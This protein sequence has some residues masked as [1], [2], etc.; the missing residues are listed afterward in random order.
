MKCFVIVAIVLIGISISRSTKPSFTFDGSWLE[1]KEHPNYFD[2]APS[3]MECIRVT[4]EGYKITGIEANGAPYNGSITW[5]KEAK[6]PMNISGFVLEFDSEVYKDHCSRNVIRF[7]GYLKGNETP[8]FYTLRSFTIE[9]YM[10]YTHTHVAT[11][12]T[13]F[14]IF[15]KRSKY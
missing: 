6:R 8:L 9:G 7:N 2:L 11:N 13:A 14:T 1:M 15:K 3:T 10:K 5:R 12:S 4:E